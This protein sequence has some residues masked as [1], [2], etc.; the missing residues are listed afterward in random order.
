[1]VAGGKLARAK[2]VSAKEVRV[3]EIEAKA[4]RIRVD[5][6]VKIAYYRVLAA[7]EI[8]MLR[9]DLADIAKDYA[10]TE[11]QLLNSGQADETERATTATI[12]C[13][14]TDPAG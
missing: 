14:L 10:T 12:E 8:Q 9:R 11:R 6:A 7:Q 3:A 5:S 4:Q 2:D 13:A 1:M